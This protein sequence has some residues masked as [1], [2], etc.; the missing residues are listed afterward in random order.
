MLSSSIETIDSLLS[1]YTFFDRQLAEALEHF[2]KTS[3]TLSQRLFICHL[4]AAMRQG[5]LCVS[6]KNGLLNPSP[7]TLLEDLTLATSELLEAIHE[8]ATTLK[9]PFMSL[10]R[11]NNKTP[12]IQ[13]GARYYF[14]RYWQIE[15]AIIEAVK[16]LAKT[17]PTLSCD[18]EQVE[19]QLKEALVANTLE[20]EQAQA[21]SQ[22]A[23][24]TLCLITGGPGTGKTHTAGQLIRFL[25][26]AC[27]EERQ[28]RFR[29]ILA[30]PT[31]KAATQLETSVLRA[32]GELTNFP[33]PQSQTLHR[34]L[35]AGGL[36][37]ARPS[38]IH[39]DCILID[40]ASMI[41]AELM[42]K[43]L[44]AVCPGTRLLF[45][46]DA[47]QLPAVDVGS[48]FSDL[49]QVKSGIGSLVRLSK[50][51]RTQCPA[52]LQF[53]RSVQAGDEKEMMRLL[54]QKRAQDHSEEA[55]IH[56]I[57]FQTT[58]EA[59]ECVLKHTEPFFRAPQEDLNDPSCLGSY[60]GRFR[61][62]SPLREGPLGVDALNLLLHHR[63]EAS[64][65]YPLLITRNQ[66]DLNIWNGEMALFY[67]HSK[68]Q[69]CLFLQE[70]KVRS[71]QRFQIASAAYGYCVSVHKSQGSE[72]DEVLLVLP[73][74]SER[75]GRELLYTAA[76]RA[77]K[78]LIILSRE[79]T[80]RKMVSRTDFRCSGISER[81]S[82]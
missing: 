56:Y 75:F 71:L 6:I 79:E 57:P 27:D 54:Y 43:L 51:R 35:G 13:D 21:I 1:F 2:Y 69:T 64:S 58:H 59:Q 46:G 19:K 52:L 22:A 61:L 30:A 28:K 74:G 9:A 16:N 4:S 33:L 70:G 36:I 8:G 17:A 50:S 76:T 42:S 53:A 23:K 82:D 24:Q 7:E 25:Y 73:D 38:R 11:E 67:S 3:L 10:S 39:A 34:L 66:P 29:L 32:V 78:R 41:D 77:K 65:S 81:L 80:L 12:L 55:G 37:N 15:T 5:H 47:D 31:G 20:I 62:L 63:K 44:S 26:L 68:S 18:E 48:I 49:L 40:E 60:L 72:W 45:L 14:K